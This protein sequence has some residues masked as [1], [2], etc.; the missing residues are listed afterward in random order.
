MSLPYG[1]ACFARWWSHEAI[2][3]PFRA[4]RRSRCCCARPFLLGE[5]AAGRRLRC[6]LA[7]A[8]DRA[9]CRSCVGV[10]YRVGRGVGWLLVHGA[11]TA[12]G[13]QAGGVSPLTPATAPNPAPAPA[14]TPGIAHGPARRTR[15]QACARASPRPARLTRRRDEAQL[16]GAQRA[17][18]RVARQVRRVACRRVRHAVA[19]CVGRAA[20]R[21][22]DMSECG[23]RARARRAPTRRQAVAAGVCV[24]RGRTARARRAGARARSGSGAGALPTKGDDVARRVR[25]VQRHTGAQEVCPHELGVAG[26]GGGGRRGLRGRWREHKP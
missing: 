10:R 11:S 22:R 25:R 1:C 3:S 2:A 18:R 8:S 23:R 13:A 21:A 19:D 14:P 24:R 20:R 7:G 12:L 17:S 9:G 4:R 16:L 26:T 5:A 15:T 6:R